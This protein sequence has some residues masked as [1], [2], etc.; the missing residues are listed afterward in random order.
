RRNVA[1]DGQGVRAPQ[2]DARS[3]RHHDDRHVPPS[4]DRAAGRAPWRGKRLVA[5][6]ADCAGSRSRTR[7]AQQAPPDPAR[8]PRAMTM[9]KAPEQVDDLDIA[10][11]GMA[12]RFPG[13][14]SLDQ[15][16]RNLA[17]GVESISFLTPEQLRAAGVE[18]Q[19]IDDPAFVNAASM[20]EG[21]D[22]FDAG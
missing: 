4:D 6:H 17:G 10:I 5:R 21:V 2:V 7:S 14:A 19:R 20:L 12:C 16:W 13:A 18:Q 1:A 9:F 3:L 8:P 22:R 15:Y 11:I